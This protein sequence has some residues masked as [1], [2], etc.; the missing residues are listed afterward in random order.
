[1]EHHTPWRFVFAQC[2]PS[3]PTYIREAFTFINLFKTRTN[4]IRQKFLLISKYVKKS[5]VSNASSWVIFVFVVWVFLFCCT[6]WDH[7]CMI[8]LST[9]IQYVTVFRFKNAVND[10]A[11]A[12]R[13]HTMLVSRLENVCWE[14][15]INDH[16]LLW[17]NIIWY[18]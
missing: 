6:F 9:P 3:R 15:C 10:C 14:V 12:A 4:Y 18:M 7:S 16:A 8:H 1:M 13:N 2:G 17:V 11:D 5:G